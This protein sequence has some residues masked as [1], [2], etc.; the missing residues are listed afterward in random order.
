M[1]TAT[2][3]TRSPNQVWVGRMFVNPAFDYLVIGGGLSLLVVGWIMYLGSDTTFLQR[4]THPGNLAW[5]FLLSNAAHFAASTVRLYTKPGAYKSLPFLTYSF[6]AVC[7][8]VLTLCIAV[9]GNIGRHLFA[10]YLTWSPYHYAAQT[11]GLSVMYSYRS[12]CRLESFD[13]RLLY[14]IC[15]IPFVYNC[16]T[17]ESAGLRWLLRMIA[18]EVD[19]G[20]PLLANA[21]IGFRIAALV[22][23]L[24]LVFKIANSKSGPMPLISL[25]LIVT[26]NIWWFIFPAYQAFIWATIFHGVQYL[27]IVII[28]HLRDQMSR[29]NNRFPAAFHAIVFY[30]MC[31][32]LGY[33]LFQCLPWF[34]RMFGFGTVESVLLVTAI[35]NIHHFIVDAYIWRLRSSDSNSK[36]VSS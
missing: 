6:P 28:F 23:P 33:A 1:S 9:P 12:G 26:N 3:E 22:A 16:L 19:N 14:W 36:I 10:L 34:Y 8:V 2:A 5:L 27:A 7:L 29:E 17:T 30:A 15:L 18:I 4:F 21:L 35:I 11:Y 25:L 31:V 13:K 20:S 24:M 32:P